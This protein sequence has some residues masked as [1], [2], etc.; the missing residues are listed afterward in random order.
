M[1]L[2]SVFHSFDI[3]SQAFKQ[4][5]T[6]LTETQSDEQSDTSNRKQNERKV[7]KVSS[8]DVQSKSISTLSK[9]HA[10]VLRNQRCVYF[11]T[12]TQNENFNIKTSS[13]QPFYG[14]VCSARKQRISQRMKSIMN[15][16][17]T[18]V[19]VTLLLLNYIICDFVKFLF[20]FPKGPPASDPAYNPFDKIL[21]RG[22]DSR[23]D[24]GLEGAAIQI[25]S[26]W[27]QFIPEDTVAAEGIAMNVFEICC[28]QFKISRPKK[29]T[30]RD[31][32]H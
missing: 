8:P 22:T 10:L 19:L 12:A 11:L 14:R 4:K 2:A 16:N 31:S 21:P 6:T 9:C 26:V 7:Y 30:A 29:R 17:R 28:G 1:N 15:I 24:K 27:L 3:I 23:V 13:V 18:N 5:L 25:G 32:I 20:N